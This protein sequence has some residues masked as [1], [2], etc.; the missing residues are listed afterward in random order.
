VQKNLR[1]KEREYW[2]QEQRVVGIN[3]PVETGS[4]TKFRSK[5]GPFLAHCVWFRDL[6]RA[7]YSRLLS[8]AKLQPTQLLLTLYHAGYYKYYTFFQRRIKLRFAN[9][10][11]YM[12]SVSLRINNDFSLNN[13]FL[14]VCV[15]ESQ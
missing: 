5:S 2:I 4:A 8:G 13:F 11:F 9:V 6:G 1:I 3:V 15:I 14:F 10:S 7:A 12:C